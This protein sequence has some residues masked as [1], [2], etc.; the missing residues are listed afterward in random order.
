MDAAVISSSNK[1]EDVQVEPEI[2]PKELKAAPEVTVKPEV[3]V[4]IEE[5]PNG[6]ENEFKYIEENG[7]TSEIFKVEIRGLPRFYGIG[8]SIYEQHSSRSL[9]INRILC[10]SSANSLT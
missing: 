7:F 2:T 10:R 1:V 3:K 4:E 8:V 9:A 6:P 5:A